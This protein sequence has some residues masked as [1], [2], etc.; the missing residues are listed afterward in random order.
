MRE[1]QLLKVLHLVYIK[2]LLAADMT[3]AT[4]VV[5]GLAAERTTTTKAI[6]TFRAVTRNVTRLATL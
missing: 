6:T 5:A 2:H 3:R 1:I 4:T